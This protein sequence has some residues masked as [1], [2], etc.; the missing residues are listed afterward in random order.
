MKAKVFPSKDVFSKVEDDNY[1]FLLK[2]NQGKPPTVQ[3]LKEPALTFWK[4]MENLYFLDKIL[5]SNP[6]LNL[7]N[8]FAYLFHSGFI[9]CDQPIEVPLIDNAASISLYQ[10]PWKYQFEHLTLKTPWFVLW[11]VTERCPLKKRCLFCYRPDEV[12]ISDP[13]PEECNRII[14]ELVINQVPWV[15]LLGGEPLCF[16]RLMLI[17]RQLRSH[18]IF[19]KVI[20]NGVLVT[21]ENA[22][23]LADAGV[24]QVAVS[25]DGL[26]KETHDWSRGEGAFD[27]TITAI[28]ILQKRVPFVSVSLTVSNRTFEQLDDLPQFCQQIGIREVY[29]S[30]LRETPNTEI[31]PELNIM[32]QEQR[33]QLYQK[34][35]NC[36]NSEL[37]VICIPECSCGRSSCVIHADG[38]FTPCPFAQRIYGNVYQEGLAT[39]WNRANHVAQE[40]G[41]IIPGPYCFRRHEQEAVTSL[42]TRKIKEL[43]PLTMSNI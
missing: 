11:E 5:E 12:K 33:S 43:A 19:V 24:N 32:T 4:R 6:R 39:L 31:S 41:R 17:I 9:Q 21:D 25:L 8:V 28:E 20:T 42:E 1:L 26:D 18:R 3:L 27:K 13:Q 2:P 40:I 35:V 23:Q 16:D 10:D 29:I 34:V 38:T 7:E 15:T 14:N 22:D 36:C 37:D 30:P